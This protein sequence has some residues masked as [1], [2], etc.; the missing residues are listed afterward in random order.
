MGTAV[1]RDLLIFCQRVRNDDIHIEKV[2]IRRHSADFTLGKQRVEFLLRCQ[3]GC[4]RVQPM[5]QLRKVHHL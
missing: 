2:P 1:E 3:Y 5:P 4:L